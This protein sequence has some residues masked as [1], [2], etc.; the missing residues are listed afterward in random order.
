MFHAIADEMTVCASFPPIA[1]SDARLL[2][3]GSLPGAESLARQRYYAKPQNSFWRIMGALVGAGPE[4]DYDARCQ[5]LIDSRLALWDVCATAYREGSLDSA[6][7]SPT[8]NDFGTFF[9]THPAISRICFNGRA[10]ESLFVRHVLPVSDP[11]IGRIERVVL[12]STSPA[13]AGMSF[14]AKLQ[15]WRQGLAGVIASLPQESVEGS[16]D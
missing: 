2:I 16:S 12:P 9:T 13:H 1:R 10:A 6:I 11:A 8:F 15:C 3:L 7:R 5:R 14:D 4:L